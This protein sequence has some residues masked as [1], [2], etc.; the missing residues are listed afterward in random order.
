MALGMVMVIAVVVSILGFALM[1]ASSMNSLETSRYLNTVK[2]FWL[3]DAGVQLSDKRA[4]NQ[5]WASFSKTTSDGG[6]IQVTV[7]SNATPTA[8]AECIGIVQGATQRVQ[9]EYQYL[10]PSFNHALFAANASSNTWYFT[11][12]GIGNPAVVSGHEINGKDVIMGDVFINGNVALYEQSMISNGIAP[13]TYLLRGDV[14]ATG[15]I[16]LSNSASVLGTRYQYQTNQPVPNVNLMNYASNNTWNVARE[17]QNAGVSSGSLPSGHPLRNIVVKNPSNRAAQNNST[18]GVDDFYFEP[19]SSYYDN[20]G[21][22]KGA[23]T[24]LNL[25]TRTVYYVDGHVWFNNLSVYGF[26][27]SG[28]ATIASTRDIHISDNLKYASTNAL[29]GLIAAGTYNSSGQRTDGGNVY[30]GDPEYGTMYTA[31]AFMFAANNFLYN[32]S[33]SNPS[34]QMEPDTGFQ[35]YG[36]YAAMNQIRVYRD[37]YSFLDTNAANGTITPRT[38]S[39]WFD[40]TVN[41]WR[42]VMSTNLLTWKTNNMRHYQMTLKYDERIRQQSTQ[43]PRLPGLQTGASGW[44]YGGITRWILVPL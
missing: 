31:D 26:K 7:F 37:W 27:V 24:P 35:V 28:T 6:G 5:N 36:N 34:L 42:D 9:V 3:A 33:S 25:G 41:Q 38:N 43:P 4:F 29:L 30:F 40:P 18:P 15:S 20:T 39:A 11:L 8:Y 10:A 2:A 44:Y 17:F 1:S 16:A 13:N 21:G 22:S 12:R 19:Q 23:S 14:T 32:A